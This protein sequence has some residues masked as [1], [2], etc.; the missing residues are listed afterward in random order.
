MFDFET[1][2]EDERRR[3]REAEAG[4][5]HAP[6]YDPLLSPWD[7][8]ESPAAV[9]AAAED[10]EYWPGWTGEPLERPREEAPAAAPVAR[11]SSPAGERAAPPWYGRSE[12]YWEEGEVS[13]LQRQLREGT[14]TI[15][16]PQ[17]RWTVTVREVAET[18]LLALLIFLAVRISLQN[19]RVE[20]ASMQPSLENGEYLIVNKLA[21]SQIDMSV[22]NFLPFYETEKEDVHHLW[23]TPNRGDVVVFRSP[24]NLTRDFIKRIIGE[25]GDV[26]AI[27]RESGGVSVNGKAIE[28]S[29][30]Q[31][32]TT[33]SEKCEWRVPEGNYFVMGD[34]R[35]NSSDSRQGWFVPEGN[36]IGKALITYWHDGGPDLKLAPNHS[37][38]LGS[39]AAAEE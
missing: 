39:P 37:T 27:D 32:K 16:R 33:C 17:R 26:V 23:E 29:Y 4:K 2:D 38:S 19:F 31:G 10:G 34:N 28:E 30:L 35:Q 14:I 6:F 8:Y 36:I 3:R 20:G 18:V 7:E 9:Q 1:L 24:T 15:P 5:E 13:V 25:P 22:F 12:G 11:E 21:Y